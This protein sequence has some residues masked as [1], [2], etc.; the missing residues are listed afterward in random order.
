MQNYINQLIEDLNEVEENPPSSSFIEIPPHFMGSATDAELALTPYK[1]IEEWTG[2]KHE[3]FPEITQLKG[4][5][6]DQVNKAIFK[7]LE[8]LHL[9]LLDIPPNYPPELLYETLTTSW[10]QAVQYLPLSGMDLKFCT[11]NP[12]S[13]PYGE[14]CQCYTVE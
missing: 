14:F 3:V 1:T 6:W 10:Q 12:L 2:I 13:C 7:V 9:E 11:G 8:S 5:Q 4:K